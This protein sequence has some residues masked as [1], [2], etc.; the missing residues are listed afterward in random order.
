MS[1]ADAVVDA[2]RRLAP[3]TSQSLARVTGL[4]VRTVRRITRK[5]RA[6]GIVQAEQD[7]GSRWNYRLANGT[8]PTPDQAPAERAQ[9]RPPDGRTRRADLD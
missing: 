9:A 6:A 8:T 5:L 7:L 3:V 2:I 4:N 1:T